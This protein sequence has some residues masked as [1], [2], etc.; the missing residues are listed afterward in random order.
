MAV[1]TR[2]ARGGPKTALLKAREPSHANTRVLATCLQECLIAPLATKAIGLS[3]CNSYC[4][5]FD[6]KPFRYDLSSSLFEL[7]SFVIDPGW[8]SHVKG[9]ERE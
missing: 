4:I 8:I 6:N 7:T 1:S 2:K 5:L 3:H 9:R